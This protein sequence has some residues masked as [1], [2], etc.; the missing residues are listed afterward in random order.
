MQIDD[1]QILVQINDHKDPHPLST[2]NLEGKIA[3]T[4]YKILEGKASLPWEIAKAAADT[5]GW[6]IN[7]KNFKRDCGGLLESGVLVMTDDGH[8]KVPKEIDV[9]F[10]EGQTN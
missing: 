6:A 2:K 7:P 5:R 3:Y 8:Y 1:S 10:S 4:V 9:K